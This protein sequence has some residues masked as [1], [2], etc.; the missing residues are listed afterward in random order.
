MRR[1]QPIEKFLTVEQVADILQLS[2]SK[3]YQFVENGTIVSHKIGGSV[4]IAESDLL[5]Y[6]SRCRMEKN[7]AERPPK[8]PRLR[9]KHIKL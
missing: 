1:V 4:R 8:T 5:D 2:R 3:I 9:L 6:L 7:E